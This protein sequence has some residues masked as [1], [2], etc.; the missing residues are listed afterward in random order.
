MKTIAILI[1]LR[2][3]KPQ[4]VVRVKNYMQSK[5]ELRVIE[6]MKPY[7]IVRAKTS[8]LTQQVLLSIPTLKTRSEM[9]AFRA[10]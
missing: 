6:V 10:L 8:M 9:I 3:L 4:T 1:A 7:L 5:I 2:C